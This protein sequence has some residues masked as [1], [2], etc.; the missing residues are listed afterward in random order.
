[1][2]QTSQLSFYDF[3]PNVIPPNPDLADAAERPFNRLYDAVKAA[4]KEK[5]ECFEQGGK[6]LCTHDGQYYL[7]DENT[8]EPLAGPV[9]EEKD[10]YL[11]FDGEQPEGTIVEEVPQGYVVLREEAPAD[12]PATEA[13]ESETGIRGYFLL[14]DRP[15]LTGDDIRN[16][17]QNFDPVSNVPNVTF[18]FTDEGQEAFAEVTERIAQRGLEK[19]PACRARTS[20]QSRRRTSPTRSRS[21]WTARSSRARSSTSRR[22]PR[23]SRATRALRSRAT[24]TS[25]RPRT[26]PSSCGSARCRSS[27]R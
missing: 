4:Q 15:E 6:P 25:P 18:D 2:G 24:S 16:P 17:E 20:P 7:F 21:S 11:K 22:T 19:P 26:S 13:D 14:K 12:D 5:P 3:E 23:A 1:M 27:S 8:L 9:T 10:L